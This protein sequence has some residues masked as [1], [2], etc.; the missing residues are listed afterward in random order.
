MVT[1]LKKFVSKSAL[2]V[3]TNSSNEATAAS[4]SRKSLGSNCSSTSLS[5]NDTSSSSD[6]DSSLFFNNKSMEQNQINVNLE[7]LLDA[8]C[9]RN[10]TAKITGWSFQKPSISMQN[11]NVTAKNNV[12]HQRI[13]QRLVPCMGLTSVMLKNS[14][15]IANPHAIKFDIKMKKNFVLLNACVPHVFD[16]AR[17]NLAELGMNMVRVNNNN[18][19]TNGCCSSSTTTASNDNSTLYD[20]LERVNY[21]Q[22]KQK[23]AASVQQQQQ[24]SSKTSSSGGFQNK[25]QK[26]KSVA[27]MVA[28]I[29]SKNG[30][31][32]QSPPKVITRISVYTK[33]QQRLSA[34]SLNNESSSSS[35]S[36]Q[37]YDS[38][39]F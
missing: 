14:R 18:N 38:I 8:D 37:Q 19:N 12:N 27:A 2:K 29:N 34:V 36:S 20:H 21:N 31:N 26:N 32:V 22:M 5:S 3:L 1:R 35:S 33:K 11:N 13:G 4:N 9:K 7:K 39:I 6:S 16:N 24:Q 17:M 25:F 15:K 28:N 23:S 30:G 10:D